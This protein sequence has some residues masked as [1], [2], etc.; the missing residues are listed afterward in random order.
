MAMVQA[1]ISQAL[2]LYLRSQSAAGSR[3]K[4]DSAPR[5]SK[6]SESPSLGRIPLIRV[7]C[8]RRV[9]DQAG[10]TDLRHRRRGRGEEEDWSKTSL[11]L[12]SDK[13]DG[14]SERP[15]RKKAEKREPQPKKPSASSASL[16]A[17]AAMIGK[18]RLSSMF[19]SS[20]FK[21]GKDK[22]AKGFLGCDSI[23]DDGIAEFA[24]DENDRERQRKH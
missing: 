7:Q 6:A 16:S 3:P 17:A 21:K 15:K 20:V 1:S 9:P 5:G 4:G 12:S 22:K 14:E 13:S 2:T 18:Q 11:P 8:R 10:E 23:V 19:T 24:L